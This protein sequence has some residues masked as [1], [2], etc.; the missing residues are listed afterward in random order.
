MLHTLRV[1]HK[2][3]KPDNVLY[4]RRLDK[5]VLY[6]FGITEYVKKNICSVSEAA[7]AGALGFL[8]PE[9]QQLMLVKLKTGNVEL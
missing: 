7:C 1:A 9:T 3:I 4:C 6:D 5:F 2:N 8:G